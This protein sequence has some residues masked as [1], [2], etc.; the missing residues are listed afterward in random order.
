MERVTQSAGRPTS[1][2]PTPLIAGVKYIVYLWSERT[3]QWRCAWQYKTDGHFMRRMEKL[4]L[5]AKS[6]KIGVVVYLPFTR[7]P[8]WHD[9]WFNNGLMS[10]ELHERKG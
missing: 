8:E 7:P 9:V 10:W 3:Q 5:W 1:V 4:S 6:E 2:G